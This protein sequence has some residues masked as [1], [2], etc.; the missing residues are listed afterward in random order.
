MNRQQ[1]DP[2]GYGRNG[3]AR[4]EVDPLVQESDVVAQGAVKW[5]VECLW[6]QRTLIPQNYRLASDADNLLS[7]SAAGAPY[8]ACRRKGTRR[9]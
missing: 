5:K 8:L 3:C 9:V 2:L 4:A 6:V 7:H 1:A